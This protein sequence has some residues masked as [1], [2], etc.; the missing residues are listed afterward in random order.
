MHAHNETI[1][2]GGLVFDMNTS[3]K[4]VTQRMSIAFCSLVLVVLLAACGGGSTGAASTLTP[5]TQAP[6]PTPTTAAPAGTMKTYTGAHFSI[7]YPS[8][9]QESSS[10]NQVTFAD[11]LVSKDIMTIV[12]VPN[13]MGAQS[14]SALADTTLPLIEKTLLKNAQTATAAPTTTVGSDTWQQR[15]AT[16]ELAI[17]DPGTQGTLY[18]LVDNHPANA[19]DT[20]AYEIYYYGPTST[21]AQSNTLAFQPMLQSFKFTA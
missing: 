4:H 10:G 1:D 18:M 9:W 2:H 12:T 20:M 19:S 16:G 17:T 13:P 5:T 6:T 11:P 15:S 7:S 21:F 3:C 8:T 14:A